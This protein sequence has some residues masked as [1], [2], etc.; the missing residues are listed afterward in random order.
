MQL[1]DR[2]ERQLTRLPVGQAA[3]W[4]H[5]QPLALWETKNTDQTR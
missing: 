2:Q 5:W 4:P 1:A 3:M